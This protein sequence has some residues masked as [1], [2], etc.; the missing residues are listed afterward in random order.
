MQRVSGVLR[1]TGIGIALLVLVAAPFFRGLF[2]WTELLPAIALVSLAFLLWV[3]G[4]RLGGLSVGVPGG[5]VGGALLALVG[6]YLLQFFWASFPRGNLDWLLRAVAGWY[7]LAMFRAEDSVLVRRF[8]AWS[9]VVGASALAVH[10]L[11]EFTGMRVLNAELLNSLSL[12]GLSSRMYTAF[13]YPNT[14]AIYFL[15]ALFLAIGLGVESGR[16]WLKGLVGGLGALL[17]IAFFFTISRGAVVVVPFGLILL[18]LGLG[19][20]HRW[21]GLLL[22]GAALVPT[23]V[24]VGPIGALAAA[25]GFGSAFAWIGAAVLAGALLGALVGLLGRLPFR[26]QLALVA[27]VAVIGAVGLG[28][29]RAGRPLL[30]KQASRLFEINLQTQNVVLRLIYD[31]DALRM[32]GDQP[33]G[34]GGWGWTRSYR[35]YATFNYTA[36]ETHNHFAQTAV[37]AGVPG[38]IAL[39]TALLAGL[40]GAW[41]NRVGNPLGWAMAAG[42]ALI[43]GHSLIDFDLSYGGVWLMLWSLLGAALSGAPKGEREGIM[44]SGAVASALAILVTASALWQGARLTEEAASLAAKGKNAESQAVAARA[45][46]WDALNSEALVQTAEHALLLRAVQVDPTN[47]EAWFKLAV[48]HEVRKEWQLGLAA[49]Q[50]AAELDPWESRYVD[51]EARLAG[52]LMLDELAAGRKDSAVKKAQDLLALEKAWTD[53]LA[54]AKENQHLWRVTPAKLDPATELRFGQARFLQGDL[55]GAKQPL[56]KAAQVGLLNSEAEVWLYA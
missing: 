20:E 47:P 2:F 17:A 22:L 6:C 1:G 42:A 28:V 30:P 51:K 27:V 52:F 24:A 8:L 13:Q 40:W 54:S 33:L 12:V 37:D 11:V 19:R 31:Q 55:A 44:A 18:F 36:R 45:V 35:Q 32:V 25:R 21:P 5:V 48:S 50:K 49:T 26:R 10:G 46:A 53:R 39:V 34:R 43:A 38:L 29:G 23:V 7:I 56:L 4:R 16:A 15:V 14:A 9:F 3:I 41:R